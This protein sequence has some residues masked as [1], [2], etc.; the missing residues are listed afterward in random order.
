MGSLV[1][2]SW[3]VAGIFAAVASSAPSTCDLMVKVCVQYILAGST[4]FKPSPTYISH[5]R[6]AELVV[7]R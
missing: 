5:A 6:F 1:M 4:P 3:I 2:V 7:R